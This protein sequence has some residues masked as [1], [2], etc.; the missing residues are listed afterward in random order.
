MTTVVPLLAAG[1]GELWRVIAD[2][3]ILVVAAI[4]FGA[5]AERFRVSSIVGYLVG[6]MVVGPGALDFVTGQERIAQIAELGVVLLMFAIGLEFSPRKLL[7]L[8]RVPLVAGPIQLAGTLGLGVI[9]ARA[10]GSSLVEAVT[11][12]A[13]VSLSSTVCVLRILQDRSELDSRHGRA[14][15]GIL[16]FQDVAV[17]PLVLLVS[18]LMKGGGAGETLLTIGKT[19]GIAAIFVGVLALLFRYLVPRV[20]ALAAL[21]RNRDFP[22]L[23]AVVLAGGAAWISNE[24]GVSPSLGAFVAG[25]LLAVSP[26]ATQIRSDIQPLR[27]LLVALFFGAIG[28]LGDVD[29]LGRNLALVLGFGLLLV[30]G[31]ALVTTVATRM[32]GQSWR[33]AVIS[34]LALAQIGEFSFVIATIA[35]EPAAG[36]DGLSAEVFHLLV[37]VTLVSLVATPLLFATGR[38][39]AAR[40]GRD[41]R[42]A[43]GREPEETHSGQAAPVRIVVVGFGPAA[44]DLV[45]ALDEEYRRDTLVIDLSLDNVRRAEILGTRGLVGDA[46]QVETLEHLHLAADT[47]FVITVPDPGTVRNMIL[48]L[49]RRLPRARIVARGRYHIHC[50][51]LEQVGADA[52]VDEEQNVGRA[53]SQAL[54]RLLEPLGD[55]GGQ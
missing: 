3:L 21:R 49:R 10:F 24:G 46:G 18:A 37:S 29:W 53:L 19:A 4:L 55:D 14:S 48:L 17:V 40:L 23:L 35:R 38:V 7:K 28:M 39:L 44:R 11:I 47:I 33:V 15:L 31:K 34:G 32:A 1:S 27:A 16:L 50:R 42:V 6:G 43:E 45:T 52:V 51:M 12:G 30:I 5:L 54:D 22:V 13:M 8:G 36:A 20:Q 9:A 41:D 26:F 25:V 2:V